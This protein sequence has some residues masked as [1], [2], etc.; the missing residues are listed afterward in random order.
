[1][2][3]KQVGSLYWGI[4]VLVKAAVRSGKTE[5]ASDNGLVKTFPKQLVINKLI[6][7]SSRPQ[8][9]MNRVSVPF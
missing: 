6:R 9:L 1:M 5:D 7:L 8:K 4:S 3:Q 2:K